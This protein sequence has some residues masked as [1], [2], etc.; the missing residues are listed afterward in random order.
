G[1]DNKGRIYL[2]SMDLTNYN[3][4]TKTAILELNII[5]GVAIKYDLDSMSDSEMADLKKKAAFGS[6]SEKKKTSLA[7]NVD[8]SNKIIECMTELTHYHQG[9]CDQLDGT[10]DQNDKKCKSITFQATPSS[11]TA[12]TSVGTLQINGD[13]NITRGIIPTGTEAATIMVGDDNGGYKEDGSLRIS[14]QLSL[15]KNYIITEGNL[16]FGDNDTNT[17]KL[18]PSDNFTITHQG[19][20]DDSWAKLRLG[21][22]VGLHG[23]GAFLGV[24]VPGNPDASL[25]VNGNA[26][27]E[28]DLTVD[29]D[30]TVN[31]T[32]K[33]GGIPAQFSIIAS[34]LEITGGDLRIVKNGAT[35]S[36]EGYNDNYAGAF[37]SGD[38]DYVATRYW[39]CE[40]FDDRLGDPDTI[41]AVV[42]AL[43]NYSGEPID[44]LTWGVCSGIEGLK[45]DTATRR[46]VYNLGSSS[47]KTSPL[48]VKSLDGTNINSQDYLLSSSCSGGNMYNGITTDAEMECINTQTK[49]QDAIKAET[50]TQLTSWG[51]T[52]VD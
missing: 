51:I 30:M 28:N 46:C 1:K 27:L 37:G 4:S 9:A 45:Y 50:R 19:K 41:N 47:G 13:L 36:S 33:I 2:Q 8:G 25:H 43:Q 24:N 10:I 38:N 18:I 40:L 6:V 48:L 42:N 21:S 39:L 52:P 44:Q 49:V 7:F 23:K 34:K 17:A 16:L 5:K 12:A 20:T 26:H 35:Q 22:T 15:N 29:G 3:A 32:M 11:S 31:E 14:D